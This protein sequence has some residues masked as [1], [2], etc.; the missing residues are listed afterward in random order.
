MGTSRRDTEKT[1]QESEKVCR[2]LSCTEGRIFNLNFTLT[3]DDTKSL[4][5]VLFEGGVG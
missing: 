2:H 4:I 3:K 1:F 5:D